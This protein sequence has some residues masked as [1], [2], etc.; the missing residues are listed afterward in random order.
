MG[1]DG[2]G[3][4][5][6]GSSADVINCIFWDN[7]DKTGGTSSNEIYCLSEPVVNVMY[8]DVQGV[9]Y[10]TQL[11]NISSDPEFDDGGDG[12]EPAG[13]DGI[14]GTI[15]DEL[16]LT[17]NDTTTSPC[18]DV[19]N[20]DAA[21]SNDTLTLPR[22]DIAGVSNTGYGELNYA[23]IGA[24]EY[25]NVIYVDND[26]SASGDGRAWSTAYK[27]LQDAL[28]NSS[29]GDEIWVY[30]GTYTPGDEREDSFELKA[31]VEIYGGFT[32]GETVRDDRDWINNETILSGDIGDEGDAT[33]NSYHVVTGAGTSTT[34]LDGFTIEKGYAD[35]ASTAQYQRGGA[36]YSY[37]SSPDVINSILWDNSDSTVDD[38]D[39]VVNSVYDFVITYS[40]VGGIGIISGTVDDW[41]CI[42]VDPQFADAGNN[43][44]HLKSPE[45]RWNGS[46]W[47]TTDTVYSKCL[48]HAHP[49]Y[50]HS[51][52]PTPNGSKINMGVYGNTSEASK[53]DSDDLGSLNVLV[54]ITDPYEYGA[55]ASA[56]WKLSYEQY[57]TWHSPYNIGSFTM[58]GLVPGSYT[59]YF[60]YVSGYITPAPYNFNI[61]AGQTAVIGRG[62]VPN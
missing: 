39:V 59:V 57:G 53:V 62:Y 47:V 28:D 38:W 49:G 4:Y 45:G 50:S 3:M 27:Y 7:D 10:A 42:V 32:G 60:K 22:I 20:G 37:N 52:E 2:G 31:G 11:G 51:N 40:D 23:D 33:D 35:H 34:I 26:A 43:D 58:E 5:L 61:S 8:S 18:I 9:T 15:D 48:V 29:A 36:I 21:P 54:W 56:K 19:A 24:Y 46:S 55:P 44:F 12:T 6:S 41:D 25:S 13:D 30:K 16:R 1:S 17:Y 14:F